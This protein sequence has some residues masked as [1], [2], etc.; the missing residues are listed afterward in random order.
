M[1]HNKYPTSD[2]ESEDVCDSLRR[3]I[4]E[5]KAE[6]DLLKFVLNSIP[7][8][9]SYVDADLHYQFCN[10]QYAVE[11]GQPLSCFIGQHVAKFV[12]EQGMQRIQPHIDTVLDGHVVAYD[13]Q[14][15]YRYMLNQSVEVRYTPDK[16][17]N[18]RV[19]GFSVYVRNIT[20]QRRAEDALRLQAHFDPLTELPNRRFFSD[21][22]SQAASRA[23]RLNSRYAILFIDLDGFK[24]INDSYGHPF[25]D[26]VL[27]DVAQT[28]VKKVRQNDTFARYGGDEFALLVEDVENDKQV[29]SLADKM[30]QAVANL[31]LSHLNKFEIGASIGIAYFPDH[32][33]SVDELLNRADEAMYMAK[34]SG[35]NRYYLFGDNL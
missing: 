6:R 27:R 2:K 17:A 23:L 13:E 35:K 9:V 31:K 15:D 1:N 24:L 26:Q 10:E 16:E 7:D 32:A 28:L 21:R 20:A 3:E 19:K 30:I 14:L 11:S 33:E 5:L 29:R 22:L 25:G 12:G 18:D 4:S 8:Y 34:K